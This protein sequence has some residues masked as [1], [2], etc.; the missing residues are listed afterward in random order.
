MSDKKDFTDKSKTA[1]THF[2]AYIAR[3]ETTAP[4]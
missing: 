2:A 1:T 3:K 4:F